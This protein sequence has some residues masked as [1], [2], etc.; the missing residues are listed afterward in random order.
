MNL[1]QHRPVADVHAVVTVL[2]AIAQERGPE[3][4]QGIHGFVYLHAVA[5]ATRPLD[6]AHVLDSEVAQPVGHDCLVEVLDHE[7]A[8]LAAALSR[9]R[10]SWRAR[11]GARGIPR[12]LPP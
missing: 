5:V 2:R 1:G 4:A 6:D 12:G 10:R 8:D 3:D 9:L 11:A 7:I